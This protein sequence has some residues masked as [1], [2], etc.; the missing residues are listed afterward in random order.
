MPYRSGTLALVA[1]SALAACTAFSAAYALSF[2]LD[3]LLGAALGV[4]R[5]A[6]YLPVITWSLMS[7]VANWAANKITPRRRWVVRPFAIAG[8]IALFG[9]IAGSHPHSYGV[10]GGEFLA[11][12]APYWTHPQG[13]ARDQ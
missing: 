9:A 4:Y 13:P 11:A 3:L 1:K 10:A 12:V 2:S 6:A 8:V 5:S 7:A